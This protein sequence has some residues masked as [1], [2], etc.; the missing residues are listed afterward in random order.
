MVSIKGKPWRFAPNG[1]HDSAKGS[2][3]LIARVPG[4]DDPVGILF[5]ED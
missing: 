4:K 1:S 2:N 3:T 5:I